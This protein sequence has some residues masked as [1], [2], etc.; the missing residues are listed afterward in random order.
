MIKKALLIPFYF[1]IGCVAIVLC[2][3]VDAFNLLK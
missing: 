3:T 1:V 2:A